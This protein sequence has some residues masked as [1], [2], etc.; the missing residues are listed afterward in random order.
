MANGIR[1]GDPCVFNK[2]RSSK[3]HEGSPVRQTPEEGWR[4]YRPKPS[5]SNN[6]DEE[7][8]PKTLNDELF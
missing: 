3:Y 6:K 2:V 8:S 7:N 1:T 4:I 5:G